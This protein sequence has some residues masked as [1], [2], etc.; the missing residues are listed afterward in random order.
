MEYMTNFDK[1]LKKLI[2][3]VIIVTA[4]GL[5]F[6][7]TSTS[8]GPWYASI[9][10]YIALS[11]NW[12]DLM[13]S[14]QDWLDKPHFPFWM[15]A[16]SFKIFGIN[17]F[18]YILP[19]FLFH[20]VGALYTYKLAKYLY[21]NETIALLACLI[22]LSVFHLMMS[23]ID[24]RAEAYLLGQIMPA[25][26]YWLK[27]DQRFSLK[28]LLL[29]AFFTGLGLMTKG[30]FV[31]IT[32]VSGLFCIWVYTKRLINVIHPKW[33]LALGLSFAFALP[34]FVALYLQFDLH[35]EKIVFGHTHVSGLRWFFIDSQF[36]RFFGTGYIMST[37]PMPFHELFFIH[38]FLWSFL[39]WS[40]VY[41][42]AIYYSLRYFKR[43]D[44]STKFATIFLLGNFW[45]SFVMFSVT[46]FQ[47]DH[48]TNIIFP[49]AA[50]LSAKFMYDYAQSNHKIFTI[51]QGLALLMLALLGVII[52]IVFHGLVLALL[53]GLE[54]L[55]VLLVVK[56][57]G[58]IPFVK[59]ILL[60]VVAICMVH[61]CYSIINGYLYH[62]Y[63]TGYL[64]AQITNQHPEIAVVDYEFDSR[65]LEFYVQNK[66]YRAN[67]PAELPPLQSFYLVTQDKNWSAITANF[68]RAQLVGQVKG[69]LPEKVLPHLIN[70]REL[71]N[72]LNTYNIILIQ[73]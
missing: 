28:Y 67:N 15:A 41:P 73:R 36:G 43:Q 64:A 47:V 68:P 10:K 3:L 6:P 25:V 5:F 11:N 66:Y 63:D 48:Y 69:N 33:I 20:L 23:A 53:V 32:I 62:Q 58:Q 7:L 42:V 56:Y 57:W 31:I 30:I 72:N 55:A 9:S 44:S 2:F 16:I 12:S 45:I 22:Y 38:T 65:A 52:G 70:A 49:F 59:A 21:N 1:L 8:F 60:P 50:I 24:V 4:V 37:A 40:L 39:P 27:Y 46:T 61:I 17:S 14:N 34:E 54:I 35:P 19:G 26:Y 13:L 71:A 18:A 51:Q 29:G